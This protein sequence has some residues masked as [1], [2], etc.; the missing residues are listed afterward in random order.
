[1][2]E[3]VNYALIGLFVVVL[4]TVFVGVVTWLAVAGDEKTYD[5][6]VAYTGE[7]VS[8]L[9]PK[10]AVKYL[11][12]DVGRVREIALDR[13]NPE[14]VRL[15]LEIERGTPIKV[16]TVAVLATQG[17]TGLAFVD[18]TGGSREAE[19]LVAPPGQA[20]PQIR[21]GPSLM[22]R[23]DT[24]A[25]TLM[26]QLGQVAED[27]SRVT[28]RLTSLLDAETVASASGILR[29]LEQVTGVL[30]GRVGDL[31][32]GIHEGRVLLSNWAKASQDLPGL[33]RS[34]KDGA[35]SVHETLGGVSRAVGEID[36][37]VG[38]TRR[39][40]VRASTDTLAQLEVLLVELQQLTR[41]FQRLGADIERDPN[42]LLF[43][44]KGRD[45]GPG[46]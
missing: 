6:Y 46:E 11:G 43:G 20:Y 40:V 23:I 37:M 17:V 4:S 42:L 38:D 5:T 26:T 22:M 21:T 1:M 7:S 31:G 10:A 33:V 27:L 41:T 12:V 39:D 24:A 14:R 2:E 15:L 16:D 19:G 9:S 28:D 8:G 34:L 36:R 45:K 29:H 13:D 30:A 3:R 44:R 25:T 35:A 32:D 18:L